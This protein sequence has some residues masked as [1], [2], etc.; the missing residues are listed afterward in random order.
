MKRRWYKTIFKGKFNVQRTIG[1]IVNFLFFIS[2]PTVLLSSIPIS[3]DALAFLPLED[4]M[5]MRVIHVL[6]AHW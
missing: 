4:S 1:I 5:L 2:I 3:R 6:A